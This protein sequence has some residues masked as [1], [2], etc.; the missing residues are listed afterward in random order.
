MLY[1]TK[2]IS[3]FDHSQKSLKDTN[4]DSPDKK[5]TQDIGVRYLNDRSLV[6]FKAVS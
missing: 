6:L 1:S 2:Y 3:S 5:A 4:L